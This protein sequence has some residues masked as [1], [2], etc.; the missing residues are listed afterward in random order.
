MFDVAAYALAVLH[1]LSP[2]D[3]PREVLPGW[4]ET[5]V[6]RAARYESIAEDV[7]DV[8]REACAKAEHATACE[9]W[10]VDILE[11]V[12]WHESGF[13]PD[14]DAGRCYR[15]KD[16]RGPRC[17]GGTAW[18]LWQI[19]TGGEEAAQFARDRKAAARAALRHLRRSLGACRALA[20]ELR[21]SAYAG[22][23][24]TTTGRGAEASRELWAAIERARRVP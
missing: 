16:G 20:P 18:S 12:A 21:L 2:L 13:A 23:R 5:R 10:T 3:R 15:G 17:D 4:A 9:R 8:A 7:A 24:C 11:A 22:G 19:R 6:E 14:V 1:A